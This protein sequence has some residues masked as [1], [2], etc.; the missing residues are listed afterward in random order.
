MRFC[1]VD[2]VFTCGMQAY[3]REDNRKLK[4]SANRKDLS[5]GGGG[6]QSTLQAGHCG[7]GHQGPAFVAGEAGCL[8]IPGERNPGQE[9]QRP[10]RVVRAAAEQ[11]AALRLWS[12]QHLVRSAHGR[13]LQ[14]LLT[15]PVSQYNPTTA[16]T[17][18]RSWGF[19]GRFAL[20]QV[21]S[22]LKCCHYLYVA[23]KPELT[24]A[25]STF[26][27]SLSQQAN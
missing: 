4:R 1:C 3:R 11:A 22:P 15:R 18:M 21:Q 5:G 8:W 16:D 2:F 27:E 7:C 25:A 13:G 9:I 17:R 12:A 23:P 20:E 26:F 14:A 6:A 19:V 10:L 24:L